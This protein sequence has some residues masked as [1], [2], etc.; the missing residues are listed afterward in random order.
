MSREILN[1]M[2]TSKSTKDINDAK[3]NIRSKNLF[4]IEERKNHMKKIHLKS[5]KDK[6]RNNSQKD[7]FIK[8][9]IKNSFDILK[10]HISLIKIHPSKD[11]KCNIFKIGK[12]AKKIKLNLM[13]DENEYE[14]LKKISI[15][16]PKNTINLM[17]NEMIFKSLSTKSPIKY[18]N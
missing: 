6:T 7:I 15:N 17:T 11:K 1:K 3:I 8:N 16:S 13:K 9:N 12:K 14:I 18:K 5:I 4:S 10:E 2:H